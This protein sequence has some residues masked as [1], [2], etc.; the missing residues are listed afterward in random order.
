[1][2]SYSDKTTLPLLNINF[3]SNLFNTSD[4]IQFKK[5]FNNEK[6]NVDNILK[7]DY[8][9]RSMN[10]IDIV[11][12]VLDSWSKLIENFEFESFKNDEDFLIKTSEEFKKHKKNI[13]ENKGTIFPLG[14]KSDEYHELI[15]NKIEYLNTKI[16]E[17]NNLFS[18][19]EINQQSKFLNDIRKV[20]SDLNIDF[21]EQLF[22]TFYTDKGFQ[23]NQTLEEDLNNLSSFDKFYNY[24]KKM[25]EKYA[26]DSKF[27]IN[28]Y[29]NILKDKI[30]NG[31]LYLKNLN[32]YTYLSNMF[33]HAALDL[34]VKECYVDKYKGKY[35][36]TQEELDEQRHERLKTAS[37]RY[38]IFTATFIPF[39]Q[40][41]LTGISS[42]IKITNIENMSGFVFNTI[43]Q[44][45][46][47]NEYDGAGFVHPI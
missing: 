18:N 7:L 29:P 44:N 20:A 35:S 6:S 30:K 38:N 46:K 43:G 45:T 1:M 34:S 21:V 11:D 5:I 14:L 47:L 24:S 33:R 8:L 36:K 31:N 23:F 9:Y 28:R 27:D 16:K 4:R 2:G 42:N 12:H 41:T 3:E 26:K 25:F 17:L 40:N 15:K 19:I 22:G 32:Y 39:V 13:F 37:K 10:I